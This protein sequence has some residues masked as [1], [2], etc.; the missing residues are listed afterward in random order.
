MN[1]LTANEYFRARFGCKVYKLALD[2]GMTCPNRDGTRGSRG[3]IFCS[4]SGSGDFAEPLCGDVWTQIERAKARV[5]PKLKGADR[6]G[7]IAYFQSFTNTYAP[8]DCL[9]PL[10]TR[11]IAHPEVAALAIATRPDCLPEPV[12]DLLDRLNRIKP[13]I[14]ELGLPTIHPETAAFI[15]RGYPLEDYDRA[16]AA[17]RALGF[18]TVVHMILGLPGETEEMTAETARYIGRTADGIKLQL[19]HILEGT[20]LAELWRRGEVPVLTLAEYARTLA[21]CLA[22]LP[23]D[24]VIHRLTGDGAKR[25]L[26]A[27]L[28]SADKKHV[29]NYVNQYLAASDQ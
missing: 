27:P 7:Y 26:L 10:F 16:A 22:V 25:D 18:H 23:P 21:A 29:L 13:V 19:L 1:Y 3:C 5:A 4:A 14:V 24:I 28:W 17:L 15:R 8:V 12:L 9:E 6:V 11:A 20:D 2:G